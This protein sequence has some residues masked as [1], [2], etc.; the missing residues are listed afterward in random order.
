MKR[1]PEMF[2]ALKKLFAQFLA[3]ENDDFD[4]RD[5][6]IFYSKALQYNIEG[7]KKS[8]E[9]GGDTGEMFLEEEDITKVNRLYLFP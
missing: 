3:E 8:I 7:L 1:P 6:A 5:R 9:D 2:S 4:L